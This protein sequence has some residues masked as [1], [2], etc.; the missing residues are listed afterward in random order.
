MKLKRVLTSNVNIE[1]EDESDEEY[2]EED[3]DNEFRGI[4]DPYYKLRYN[5]I[6]TIDGKTDKRGMP[7]GKCAVT[8]DNGDELY[9]SWRH[10]K[11]EGFGNVTGHGMEARGIKVVQGY[12]SDGLIQ[13]RGHVKLT[14][15][16]QFDCNFVDSLV[17]GFVVSTFTKCVGELDK[18]TC[19]TDH[20]VT[21]P[22]IARFSR[23]QMV[24]H[25]WWAVLGGGWLHGEVDSETGEMTGDEMMYIYP[26]MINV[27]Y[28]E[29]TRGNMTKAQHT[30]IAD[31]G[32]N[33]IICFNIDPDSFYLV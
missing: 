33:E 12:Y 11:R 23:G 13:G 14:N 30:T 31:V 6:K 15:G 26:D 25:V 19:N 2:S 9:G 28:G 1:Q 29:F 27:L 21:G 5:D 32:K 7:Y 20:I 22:F 3:Y 16:C 18:D 4:G 24:G 8:L 17:D 10:N